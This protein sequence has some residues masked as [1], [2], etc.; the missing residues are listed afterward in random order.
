[1][2]ITTQNVEGEE[3]GIGKTS[4]LKVF[5]TSDLTKIKVKTECIGGCLLS[6]HNGEK[7]KKRLGFGT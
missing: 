5:L 2:L 7:K 6:M 3:K 4:C 1:M